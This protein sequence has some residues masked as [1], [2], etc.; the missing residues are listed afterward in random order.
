MPRTGRR[1]PPT[2]SH[3]G[4]FLI[5]GAQKSCIWPFRSRFFQISRAVECLVTSLS[6]VNQCVHDQSRVHIFVCAMVKNKETWLHT[7][8]IITAS[9]FL[10]IQISLICFVFI[11]IF[12][13]CSYMYICYSEMY[14]KA[15]KISPF[16]KPRPLHR[17]IAFRG[18]ATTVIC[19][20]LLEKVI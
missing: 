19:K 10:P 7:C 15:W 4:L 8:L 2:N 6:S 12:C 11:F 3:F 17:E 9:C 18:R 20:P 16:T 13:W 14:L 1:Q 5:Y